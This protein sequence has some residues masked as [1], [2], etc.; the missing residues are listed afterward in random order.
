ME[1]NQS[2]V[3]IA[4][5]KYLSVVKGGSIDTWMDI[6]TDDAVVEFPYS[7]DPFPRLLEGKDAIYAYYK[8]IPPLFEL[9]KENSFVAYLSSDPLVGVVEISLRFFI[10]STKK[11]YNQDYICIIKVGKEGRIVF[12]REYSDP[13]RGQKAFLSDEVTAS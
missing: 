9:L 12:Y 1:N 7:P 4:A 2:P 3:I 10:K 13:I 6:W 11:E 8:N 5:Q